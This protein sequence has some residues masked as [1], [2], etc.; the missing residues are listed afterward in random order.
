MRQVYYLAAAL[1]DAVLGE[2]AYDV[3]ER[4][5]GKIIYSTILAHFHLH[6]FLSRVHAQRNVGG[7]R[8]GRS[9]PCQIICVFFIL[10]VYK[11]Q[12]KICPPP[13]SLHMCPAACAM[14]LS[15][16]RK[17]ARSAAMPFSNVKRRRGKQVQQYYNARTGKKEGTQLCHTRTG[18]KSPA[19]PFQRIGKR[20]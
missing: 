18:Q 20:E 6:I 9:R 12:G 5:V 3:L 15:E 8:P 13:H 7:Q 14:P 2:G 1:A 10:D 19:H 16:Q 17:A 4:F 11:R